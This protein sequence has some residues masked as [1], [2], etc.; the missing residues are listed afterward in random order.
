MQVLGGADFEDLEI[1]PRVRRVARGAREL[2]PRVA[3]LVSTRTEPAVQV[4]ARLGR[5]DV[6]RPPVEARQ[7]FELLG[8]RDSERVVHLVRSRE[9]ADLDS[10]APAQLERLDPELAGD[11]VGHGSEHAPQ[12]LDL[13]DL[14]PFHRRAM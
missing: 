1:G 5:D 14:G 3:R 4:D 13:G 2:H 6:P 8:A 12:C 9:E 10:Q 7:R 11:V